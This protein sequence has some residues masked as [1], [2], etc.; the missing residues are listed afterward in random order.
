VGTVQLRRWTRQEY[1]RLA[2]LGVLGPEE[3]VEL[4]EGEIVEMPPQ[5]SRHT[6]GVYLAYEALRAIFGV[7]FVVRVQF[8]LALG[9]YSE[10]EPDIAVVAGTGRDF[11]D[12]HPTS[13]L[14]VVEVSD[15]TLSFDRDAKAS[16]YA[17]AGIPEYWI[18]NLVQRQLEMHREPAAMPETQYGFG[19]RTRTIALPGEVVSTPGP[20][21]SRL[22][23]DDL[24]P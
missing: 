3:H 5:L 8:P 6:T 2:E 18:V 10:P 9:Q 17:A 20:A 13:A 12:A 7:G 23:V 14:L 1:E 24:L 11:A 22:A 19:Y 4:I 15:T 16:L 21:G